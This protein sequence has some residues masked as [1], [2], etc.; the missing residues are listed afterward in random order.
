MDHAR[1][2]GESKRMHEHHQAG[3]EAAAAPFVLHVVWHPECVGGRRIAEELRRHF[4]ADSYRRIA[5][6]AGVTV[7]LHGAGE[8]ESPAPP[9]MDWAVGDVVAVV[10]LVDHAFAADAHWMTYLNGLV[11]QAE[12]AGFANRMFPVALDA[13]PLANLRVQALRWDRWR[14]G[15]GQMGHLIRELTHG[16]TRMVRHWLANRQGQD[17]DLRR[18]REKIQVFL[19]HSKHDQKGEAVAK[20]IRGW[21]NDHSALASFLDVDDMVPGVRFDAAIE[22]AIRHGVLVAIYTDSYSSREWCR[23]EAMLA[24]RHGVPML[25]VDCLQAQDQ[26]AF[27]YLW[28]VPVIRMDVTNQL[29]QLEAVA[30]VLLDEVFKHYLWQ[31]RIDQH[32][33]GAARTV[34]TARPPELTTAGF[35]EGITQGEWVIVHPE[36]P[37]GKEEK[38]LFDTLLPNVR[39][40]TLNE[41]LARA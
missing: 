5:G 4:A 24:K 17:D 1:A 26:R 13:S 21:L 25:V 15:T 33:R 28:N 18:Y 40:S 41:W 29:E 9:A 35:A 38:R 3:G 11:D 27:P 30:S 37:L 12:E 2:N 10:A 23:R 34:F 20:A 39:L 31:Q 6:G 16:F 7:L 14:E 22:D 36:P 19:S 8:P 32:R